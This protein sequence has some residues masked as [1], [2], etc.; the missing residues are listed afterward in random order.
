[1]SPQKLTWILRSIPN[2]LWPLKWLI[3]KRSLRICGKNFRF[4][5]SSI[6]NDHR[7][8]EIGNDVFFGERTI[9]NT[10][11]LVKIGNGVMFGPDVMIMGGDHNLSEIG[12]QMRYVK[13]GGVNI[14][15]ILEDDVWVG[16]RVLILKG[17]KIGEG[18]IVGAGSVVTKEIPPYCIAIGSP[19]K[20]I[21][22]RFSDDDLKKHLKL[23]KSKYTYDE[24]KGIHM[25]FNRVDG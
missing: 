12:V 3:L 20:I 7:L 6:F 19:C 16:A 17:V 5:P 18:S 15:V 21:K 11:V 14:P 1:M 13:T 10:E 4:S 9:I 25:Q 8:I 2:F 23:I 22:L 24:I